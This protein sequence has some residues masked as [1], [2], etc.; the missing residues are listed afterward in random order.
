MPAA[1]FRE[2]SRTSMEHARQTV[3]TVG[4]AF[5]HRASSLT[6]RSFPCWVFRDEEPAG[7]SRSFTASAQPLSARRG[8]ITESASS[9]PRSMQQVRYSTD[10][11]NGP[12][13]VHEQ[14][15]VQNRDP[16][17][18]E[19]YPSLS[20]RPTSEADRSLSTDSDPLYLSLKEIW[21][22][23]HERDAI[24]TSVCGKEDDEE[25]EEEFPMNRA[26]KAQHSSNYYLSN[27][28]PSSTT[29]TNNNHHPRDRHTNP[30][31]RRRVT[32]WL[33]TQPKHPPSKLRSSQSPTKHTRGDTTRLNSQTTQATI[34]TDYLS[35]QRHI[36]DLAE[37]R[38]GRVFDSSIDYTQPPSLPHTNNIPEDTTPHPPNPPHEQQAGTPK[39]RPR[40]KS[41][42]PRT[43][44]RTS[45]SASPYE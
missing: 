38:K 31:F 15:V 20:S 8:D 25:E 4:T 12:A 16:L 35:P 24:E 6:S 37:R 11:D 17:R 42:P 3:G 10:G 41:S 29:S 26:N 36:P 21:A 39:P 30:P 1:T 40:K 2:R 18:D 22:I 45:P 13:A 33:V 43:T 14:F 32:P 9:S 44:G 28:S 7:L 23:N 34:S 19:E 27:K 5:R